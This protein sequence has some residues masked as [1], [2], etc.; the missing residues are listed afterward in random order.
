MCIWLM[1][2]HTLQSFT[3]ETLYATPLHWCTASQ[4]T[5]HALWQCRP[6]QLSGLRSKTQHDMGCVDEH[7]TNTFLR[8]SWALQSMDCSYMWCGIVRDSMPIAILICR[9]LWALWGMT[10]FCL[11]KVSWW[12]ATVGYTFSEMWWLIWLGTDAV[13]TGHLVGLLQGQL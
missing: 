13:K 11:F 9:R 6:T 7:F 2:S 4:F 3:A 10:H 5:A 8:E 12:D 1:Q